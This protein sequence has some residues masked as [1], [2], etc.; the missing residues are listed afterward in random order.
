VWVVFEDLAVSDRCLDLRDIQVVLKPLLL[1]METD[2]RLAKIRINDSSRF[3]RLE[4]WPIKGKRGQKR[5][6]G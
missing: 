1:R 4:A 2:A 3:P 5:D 6:S